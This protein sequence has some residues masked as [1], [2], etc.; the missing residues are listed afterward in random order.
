M[1]HINERV[2]KIIDESSKGEV[3]SYWTVRAD[4]D[5]AATAL[6]DLGYDSTIEPVHTYYVLKTKKAL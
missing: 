1:D 6:A 4:I 3:L 2:K 5:S